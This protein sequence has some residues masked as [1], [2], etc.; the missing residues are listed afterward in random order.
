M[1]RRFAAVALGL[2]LLALPAAGLAATQSVQ[3]DDTANDVVVEIPGPCMVAVGSQSLQCAGVAYTASPDSGR[4]MFTAVGQQEDMSFSGDQDENE[5][6]HYTLVL[7]SVLSRKTGLLQA[8]GE[9]QM[10]MAQDGKTV[11]SI[12]CVARTKAGSILLKAAGVA[13]TG[14]DTSSDDQDDDDDD[15]G[16][17]APDVVQ[18]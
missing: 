2:G 10:Q 17:G 6:G 5:D 16:D 8:K 7:D 4:V 11:S 15:D 3:R 12:E 1:N 14:G 13:K 18:A 9:C